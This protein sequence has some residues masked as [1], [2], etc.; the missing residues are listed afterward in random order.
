MAAQPNRR[1][2]LETER[3]SVIATGRDDLNIHVPTVGS[4]P[5]AE[6][7]QPSLVNCMT[8]QRAPSMERAILSQSC[9]GPRLRVRSE[10]KFTSH[11]IAVQRAIN[12]TACGISTEINI[13]V[14]A[15]YVAVKGRAV[16]YR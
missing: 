16:Q 14:V 8:S 10:A 15:G 4:A 3:Q 11:R 2:V 9:A 7:R 12:V 6:G 13:E 5:Y 1:M